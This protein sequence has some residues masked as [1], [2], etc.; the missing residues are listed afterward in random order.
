MNDNAA[1]AVNPELLRAI[2]EQ[3]FTAA[4][5]WYFTHSQ[6]TVTAARAAAKDYANRIVEEQP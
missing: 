5:Q 4:L 2:A 6:A 3:S 1:T